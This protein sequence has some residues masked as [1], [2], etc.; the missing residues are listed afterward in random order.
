MRFR[1]YI[2]SFN[3]RN[4][5][6]SDEDILRMTLESLFDNE[7]SILAQNSSIGIP[8][9]D[10]LE[11]SPNTKNAQGLDDGGYWQSVLTPEYQESFAPK[12]QY[13][14]NQ[15]QNAI[16]Y[17]EWDDVDVSDLDEYIGK[18]IIDIM[19]ENKKEEYEVNKNQNNILEGNIEENIYKKQ[20]TFEHDISSKRAKNTLDKYFG[21]EIAPALQKAA[22]KILPYNEVEN[23]YYRNSLKMKDGEPLTDEFLKENDI[24][25]LKDITD[26]EKSNYYKEQL[27]K[28]YGLALND[29]DIDEKLKDKKIVVPKEN[30]RLYQYAKNSEAIEKW[31][32]DNYDR[33]KNGE[34][35]LNDWIEFP[36]SVKDDKSRG[37]F[38]TIH[39]AN[40]NNV[41]INEDNSLTLELDDNYDFAKWDKH[42]W[43]NQDSIKNNLYKK[44]IVNINNNAYE[45]Q[46]NGQLENFP[47]TMRLKYTKEELEELLRRYKYRKQ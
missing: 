7:P 15:K 12:Q 1:N 2:N 5:I 33:I 3:R 23:E 39:N 6:Y 11:Q 45:Q 4:R 13:N 20:K 32:V 22:S 38:A 14:L 28:M 31:I 24:Y 9:F 47:I 35:P 37:L 8:S 46:E 30:S 17:N 10:E 26:P 25:G 16:D 34:K 27:A 36:S 18:N 42:K 44:G 29:P 40:T 21:L 43:N 19:P 41:K